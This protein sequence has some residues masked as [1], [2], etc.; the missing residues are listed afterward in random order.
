MKNGLMKM[1]PSNSINGIL[2]QLCGCSM[3]LVTARMEQWR[4]Y[5]GARGAK[6]PQILKRRGAS[7]PNYKCHIATRGKESDHHKPLV[8]GFFYRCDACC[9]SLIL[10]D[11][12]KQLLSQMRDNN[13]FEGL[14]A[15]VQVV[16]ASNGIER[17]TQENRDNGDCLHI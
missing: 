14:L 5:I 16:A 7:P 4:F 17:L 10:D 9:T 3:T 15:K 1:H 6:P 13:Q 11:A 2:L 8:F 12:M